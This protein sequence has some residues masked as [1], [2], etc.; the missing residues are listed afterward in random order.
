MEAH[1]SQKEGGNASA[2]RRTPLLIGMAEAGPSSASSVLPEYDW[3]RGT[4]DRCHPI[5][6]V[7][8]GTQNEGKTLTKPCCALSEILPV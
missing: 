5:Y 4:V 2:G 7:V 3:N 6:K 1:R 8:E